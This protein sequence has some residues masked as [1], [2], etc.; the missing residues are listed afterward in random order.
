[1]LQPLTCDHRAEQQPETGDGGRHGSSSTLPL[2]PAVCTKTLDRSLPISKPP[3]PSVAVSARY[4]HDAP[5]T[6]A[7]S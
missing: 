7:L 3:P 1:M 5:I 6:K 2:S 4:S